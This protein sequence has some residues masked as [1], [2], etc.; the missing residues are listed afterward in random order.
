MISQREADLAV[1]MSIY[2]RSE[3]RAAATKLHR[4]RNSLTAASYLSKEQFEAAFN[5]LQQL[6]MVEVQNLEDEQ[7]VSVTGH[8]RTWLMSNFHWVQGDVAT[9]APNDEAWVMTPP[10][11]APE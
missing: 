6:Q 10:T 4:I 3:G 8:G 1:L 7:T 11:K 9:L 2:T 5:T